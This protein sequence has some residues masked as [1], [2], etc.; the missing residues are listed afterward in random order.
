MIHK[1]NAVLFKFLSMLVFG[2]LIFSSALAATATSAIIPAAPP[3]DAAAY[4]LIDADSGK[5]LVEHS[6]QQRLP[7]ASLTKIM[8]SYVAAS[9]IHAGTLRLDEDVD[10]SVKAWR[11]EGSRMFIKEGTR[12]KVS[13]LLRG[14]IIQSGN[15]ASVAIAEHIAGNEDAFV[16]MMNQQAARLGMNATHFMNATG[17][18][19][20]DHY[21]TASDL[22]KLT[23][24]LI[25]DFPEQY[26]IYSE[27][28]FS[29]N[30]IKQPNRNRLLWRD[31][32]VDG[33]KTGYTN[34]AGYCLIASAERKAMRLISV[35]MGARSEASRTKESQKLFTYGFRYYT[36]LQLYAAGASFKTVRIWGGAARRLNLGVMD[37]VTL[38]IAQGAVANLETTLDIQD[39]VEA[40][41]MQGQVLG[42]LKILAG[43]ELLAEI[44]LVALQ[45]I[46]EAGF[47]SGLWDAVKLF[48]TTLF[49]GD[50]L[51]L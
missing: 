22:A 7:P 10:V 1:T 11:M 26:K 3:L 13:D 27:K 25:A 20:A 28:S 49:S 46:A 18:P 47:F 12:V 17:L 2:Q 29:Y 30:G 35:V 34:A 19:D 14:I 36:T 37:K 32:F 42:Q 6:S 8:T 40:P 51:A 41:V 39:L 15:D 23:R 38:T 50:T 21:T 33:V 5:I 9:L 4:L 45:D 48:F 44:P 24:A 31:K 43:E 16:D